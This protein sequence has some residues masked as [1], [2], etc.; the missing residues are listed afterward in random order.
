MAKL[1]T[2]KLKGASGTEYSFNVYPRDTNWN[3]GYPCV[4]Y[5]SKRSNTGSHTEIY[6]GET[7]DIKDR[8]SNH[9]RQRCF[10]RHGYNA[11]SVHH[12]SDED[13]RTEVETDLRQALDPPCN[14]E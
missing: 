7:G 2:L 14:R 12:E 9:H 1:G 8:F 4:Y 6:I 3:S 11:I 13:R 10:D 5:V